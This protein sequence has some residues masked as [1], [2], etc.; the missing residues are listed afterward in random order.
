MLLDTHVLL[1]LLDDSPRLGARTRQ[2]LQTAGTV[3]VSSAS[4]WELEIKAALGKIVIPADLAAEI[5]GAGLR[6]LAIGH[7]HT[8]ALARVTGLVH[9]DPFDR[10]LLA[11][12]A[13]ER[14]A[15]LTV[16]RA[17][18]GSGPSQVVDASI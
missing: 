14:V 5:H 17:L 16:D 9:A 11:Q 6:E 3:W 7:I 8:A 13:V 12:A 15:F 1:W 4:L 10:M 2:A 18:P